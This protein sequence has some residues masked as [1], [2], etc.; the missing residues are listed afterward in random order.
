MQSLAPSPGSHQPG[1]ALGLDAGGTQTRWALLTI[2]GAIVAEG[3]MPPLHPTQLSTANGRDVWLQTLTALA[4]T[5]ATSGHGPVKQLHA[6]LTGYGGQDAELIRVISA[7]LRVPEQAIS[8]SNDVEMAFRDLFEPGQGHLVY[9]GTGS[10]AIH[11][12]ADGRLHRAGGLGSV[13]DDAGGGYWIGREALRRV[14]RAEDEEP[15]AWRRSTLAQALMQRLGG[16]D[17]AHTRAFLAQA[18]RGAMGL[19]ATTVAQCADGDGAALGVLQE[20]GRELARLASILVRR[21]GPRP[22]ALAGGVWS[23]HPAIEQTCR[24]ALAHDL[25]VHVRECR[26]HHAAARVAAARLASTLGHEAQA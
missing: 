12:D 11:L 25:S 7:A 19:L 24:N 3:Q 22:I 16:P 15:G 23:L 20:A 1:L 4:S 21:V 13:L 2:R 6:A 18:D 26:G 5:L 17:W 8:L 14:W 10:I 9:A